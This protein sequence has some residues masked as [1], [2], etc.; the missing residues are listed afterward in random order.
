MSSKMTVYGS[1]L[2][3][4]T[5]EALNQLEKDKIEFVYRDITEDL[6]CLKTFLKYRDQSGAFD[7]AR[8]SGGIGIPVFVVSDGAAEIITHDMEEAL[9]KNK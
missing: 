5:V 2:C 7:Q 4:D 3:P 1:R 9:K 6:A 8:K